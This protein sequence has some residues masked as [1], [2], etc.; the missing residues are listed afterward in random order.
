MS[1]GTVYAG[2]EKDVPICQLD[3]T[4]NFVLQTV[5][6]AQYDRF[7]ADGDGEWKALEQFS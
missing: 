4:G 3:D 2:E 7:I 5:T 1:A 6:Q